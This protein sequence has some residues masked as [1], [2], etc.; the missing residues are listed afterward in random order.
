MGSGLTASVLLDVWERGLADR[1]VQRALHLLACAYPDAS[2]EELKALPIGQR[3]SRLME[4]REGLFGSRL[5]CLTACPTCG[6]K[7]EIELDLA[8]IRSGEAAQPGAFTHAL[9]ID[10]FQVQFRLPNS[11]DMLL[12]AGMA[13]A[14][15]ARQ[16]LLERCVQQVTRAGVPIAASQLPEALI[17]GIASRM[18]QIDSQADIQIDLVCPAC[19]QKWSTSFDIVS[20]LWSEINTWAMRILREVH[21]IARAYGWSEADIL[22]LSPLRRQFYLELIG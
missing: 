11:A 4:I 22:A 21:Q 13:D 17:Q 15:L 12:L 18:A 8:Q 7:L 5:T 2:F 10:N 1:P 20:Y 9:T 6:E 14:S 16:T 19:A 3:D